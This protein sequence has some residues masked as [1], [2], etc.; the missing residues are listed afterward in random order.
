VRVYTCDRGEVAGGGGGRSSSAA[1]VVN[2]RRVRQC[3]VAAQSNAGACAFLRA[4]H[5]RLPHHLDHLEDRRRRCVRTRSQHCGFAA[6]DGHP[7]TGEFPAGRRCR[8]ELTSL[9][10]PYAWSW[11]NRSGLAQSCRF[12]FPRFSIVEDR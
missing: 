7:G 12:G 10:S 9:E 11:L 8:Q 3:G 1:A 4:G 6:L 5:E 2:A